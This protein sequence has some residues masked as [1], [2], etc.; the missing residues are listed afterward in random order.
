MARNIH[1]KG[2]GRGLESLIPTAVIEAEFDVAAKGYSEQVAQVDAGLIDPNP[3]QPRTSFE[4]EMLEGLANSIRQFGILQPLVV[5]RTDS[6]RYELIAG[7]RRLRA[8][9]MLGQK[10]VPAIVRTFDD[11]EKLE[12]ALIENLQRQALNPVETATAYRKLI[13]EF[14]MSQADIAKRLGIARP[15]I[16]N[17]LRLLNLPLEAKRALAAGK[18]TEGHGRALLTISDLEKQ[19]AFLD[20]M[21]E[22][23]WN[24]RQAEEF[25]REYREKEPDTSKAFNRIERENDY[26][27]RLGSYLGTQ[28][29]MY[30]TA[31]GGKL[32]IKFSSEDDLAKFARLL[33]S[34]D[35]QN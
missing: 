13:D 9:K 8:A 28:V 32:V 11:Q 15:T 7:E 21:I 20:L 6:G 24:V 10:K 2:L 33:E 18:I 4:P 17:T 5:S 14:N 27:R 22:K 3:H 19:L 25:A 23:G 26:T 12:L 34:D 1:K 30:R 31:S 35:Q 29:Y 16:T